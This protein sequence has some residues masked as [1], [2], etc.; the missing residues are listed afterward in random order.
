M[1]GTNLLIIESINRL[2]DSSCTDIDECTL[3][4]ASNCNFDARCN[5]T[6]GS[7]ICTCNR[8]YSGDGFNC[9]GNYKYL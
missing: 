1:L 8:G 7:Y 2:I 9:S 6:N 5:N 3:P 4:G